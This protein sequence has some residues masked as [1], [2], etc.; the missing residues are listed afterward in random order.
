M[1]IL[2]DGRTLVE[3]DSLDE[4]AEV[5]PEVAV[6]AEADVVEVSP[7]VKL[8]PRVELIFRTR[9][10]RSWWTWRHS[11]WTRWIHRFQWCCPHYRDYGY[12]YRRLGRSS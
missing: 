3:K 12:N 2:V 10:R 5:V 6:V 1:P 4:E 8:D 11:R 7:T 9:S